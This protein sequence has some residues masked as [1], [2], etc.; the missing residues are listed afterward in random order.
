MKRVVLSWCAL[1]LLSVG[2]NAQAQLLKRAK[3]SVTCTPPV[4]QPVPIYCPPSEPAQVHPYSAQPVDPNSPVPPPPADL[5]KSDTPQSD[6]APVAPMDQTPNNNEQNDQPQNNNLPDQPVQPDVNNNQNLN[7]P[8]Q[9]STQNLSASTSS[10]ASSVAPNMIGDFFGTAGTNRI[11]IVPGEI[12][13]S[14][15]DFARDSTTGAPVPFTA[16]NVGPSPSSVM[17]TTAGPLEVNGDVSNVPVASTTFF[18]ADPFSPPFPGDFN[19]SE[20]TSVTS[21]VGGAY[22]GAVEIRHNESTAFADPNSSGDYN[23][24]VDYTIVDAYAGTV[25]PFYVTV[26]G[27]NLA[28][29]PGS[30]VGRMKLA[31]NTSPMPR[32]RVFVNYSYFNNTPLAAGG[33]DVNRVTPGFEKTFFDGIFSFEMRTPFA[34]TLSSDINGGIANTDDA[35]FGNLTMYLKALL[36]QNCRIA[37]AGGLGITA[38]TA[39]EFRVRDAA[40]TD[41]LMVDNKSVHLIPYVAA[42]FTPND[43]LFAQTFLQFD[44]DA[45]GNPVYATGF[46][47]NGPSGTLSQIGRPHDFTYMF[48]DASVGYWVYLNPCSGGLIRG[49]APIVEYHWNQSLGNGDSTRGTVNGVA[50]NFE[51]PEGLSVHN[52]VLGVTTILGNNATMTAGYALPIVNEDSQFDGE[53]RLTFNWLFGASRPTTRAMRASR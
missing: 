10:S 49:V 22:P 4:C 43:R 39:D 19:L 25:S 47:A 52:A 7:I 2:A 46:T 18:S 23:V 45:N 14:L 37:F 38:P 16:S 35:E 29:A 1:A 17:L 31:E 12:T 32:D 28:A 36:Y 33:V 30:G 44:V 24:F 51:A 50:Y 21:A 11:L 9:Q 34:T 13:R 15:A 6:T 42:L 48:F 8:Q 5:P 3:K 41:L 20:N 26:P 27:N 53:F 40:G